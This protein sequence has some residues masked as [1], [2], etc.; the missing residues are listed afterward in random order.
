M[1]GLE[2]Y[3]FAVAILLKSRSRTPHN[4]MRGRLWVDVRDNQESLFVQTIPGAY[5]LKYSV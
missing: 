3:C 2:P 1:H 5:G 4:T